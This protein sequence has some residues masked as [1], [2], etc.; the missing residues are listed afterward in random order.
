M[1]THVRTKA[2]TR[3]GLAKHPQGDDC[4]QSVG[5]ARKT[6]RIADALRFQCLAFNR[7][8]GRCCLISLCNGAKE[9]LKWL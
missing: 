2:Q 7:S 5:T 6:D 8:G 1:K 3:P 9:H 4:A